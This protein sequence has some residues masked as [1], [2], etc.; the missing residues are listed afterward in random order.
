ML[1]KFLRELKNPSKEFRSIPF[2]SWNDQLETEVLK[3]QIVEMEK[4]GLGGYFMH[5]R[6]GLHTE[7]L[8]EEWM[9]CIKA[10]I[11]E[12]KKTGMGAW[13]Y[14]ENGWPSGFAGGLVTALGDQYHV[15]HI[16]LHEVKVQEEVSG[17]EVLGIYHYNQENNQLRYH[18]PKEFFIQNKPNEKIFVVRNKSNPYYIDI[19][20]K[21]VVRA[22]IDRT[23]EVYYQHFADE[24]GDGMAGFF[25]DEPQYSRERMPWSYLLPDA[26]CKQYGYDLIP[27]LPAL[28]IECE[29]Y[30]KLRYDYWAL[31]SDLYLKSF[32]EQVYDWC[33]EHHCELTGHT[34]QEDSLLWQMYCSGGVMPFY[35]YMHRPGMD[36]LGR[37][38]DSPLVPKQVSSVANQLQKKFV[39]SETF[40]LCGW[41]VSFEE[42]KWIA[43][44]QF[45]NGVNLLCQHL[46]SYSIRGLRKRDYPPSLFY[47]QSWWEEYRFFN[48][49]FARLTMLLTSGT[50]VA[51]VLLLHPIKSAWIAYNLKN[52]ETLMQLDEDL[53]WATESLAAIHVDHH[54]GDE[55][56][57]ARHGSV[58]G[59]QFIIG[60]CSYE[61]VV[62]PSMRT[63]D[64]STLELLEDF[65][66]NDGIVMSIGEF[67]TMICGEVSQRLNIF[68]EKVILLDRDIHSL[69]KAM[70]SK[71]QN[72]VSIMDEQGEVGQIHYQQRDLGPQQIVYMVNHSQKDAFDC[73]ITLKGEGRVQ[74][75][76]VEEATIEDLDYS[77]VGGTTQFKLRFLPMQSHVVIQDK[78]AQFVATH[79]NNKVI[80]KEIEI[81][82]E[83]L[84]EAVDDNVLT[85]DY[86]GYQ[87]NDEPWVEKIHTIQLMDVLLKRK[88]SCDI[89]LKF[90][91]DIQ[92]DLHQNKSIYLVIESAEQFDIQ[93]N[94]VIIAVGDNGWWKDQSFK[95]IDVKAWVKLGKN[96]VI[97]K[98]KFYQSPKVYE[99]LFGDNVLESEINKLTYDVE[100]ESIYVVGDFGVIS[101][102]HYLEG[103]KKALITN[104]PFSIVNPSTRVKKGD[105]T[106]QGFS[107]FAGDIKV[108]QM[109][110][111]Q[112]EQSTRYLV[113]FD[114]LTAPM[115]KVMINDK[116]AGVLC[117]QPYVIDV[118]DLLEEGP[119]KVSLQLFASNR[120]LLGPH[121]HKDGQL[122][123][124]GPQSFADHEGWTD[125]YCFVKFGV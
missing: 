19:L 115:A 122:H 98:R 33:E 18:L 92:M 108:S 51:K 93:F 34:I 107:F 91:F 25:A 56:I 9:A 96:E 31:V 30:E 111:I 71:G 119:N 63:L 52:N 38:I 37:R 102:S 22:F 100:L 24:F 2:W 1:E 3:S 13:C 77:C 35:E 43:E 28:F 94:G 73:H 70:I 86:C 89:Q 47:Q 124:V 88:Q 112:K 110:T 53:K 67:P 65:V 114:Q 104:G 109:F 11:E 69:H 14:D 101:G 105:L 49:Y 87:V 118:T 42:L 39:L 44:W 7:Y 72:T 50:H 117:W 16:E 8:S 59:N 116:P 55:T 58:K 54:Y 21:E 46:Q 97:L 76:I 26:F 32:G 20:N 80:T 121:H 79:S 90:H 15:R 66:Q 113:R 83:W 23:H 12:G 84:V 27:L 85:L 75:F 103:D 29:G 45:V 62:L 17:E 68:K 4:A 60:Q 10:C 48:D 5:A 36:W 41:D 120:N 106:Q 64:Q 81:Q 61:V 57:I 99:A 6:G 95:K 78:S 125:T 40:A 74:R 82:N 123:T